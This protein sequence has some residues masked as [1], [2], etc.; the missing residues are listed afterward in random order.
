MLAGRTKENLKKLKDK[1]SAYWNGKSIEYF[2]LIPVDYHEVDKFL[3]DHKTI[4]REKSPHFIPV[5]PN[6]IDEVLQI[7][8]NPNNYVIS[9]YWSCQAKDLG[10]S[11]NH[12]NSA[13]S[14]RYKNKLND[15]NFIIA[16]PGINAKSTI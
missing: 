16:L 3:K 11:G 5:Y 8:S 14:I 6:S 15:K 1:I 10:H 12:P 9:A 4:I 13:M 2:E 7:L